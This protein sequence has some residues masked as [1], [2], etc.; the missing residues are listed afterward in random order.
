[1][2][3][4]DLCY[5]LN[6]RTNKFNT[7]VNTTLKMMEPNNGTKHVKFPL[8]HLMVPGNF[9]QPVIR[10]ISQILPPMIVIAKPKMTIH[11]PMVSRFGIITLFYLVYQH[12][13]NGFSSSNR[14]ITGFHSKVNQVYNFWGKDR[15]SLKTCNGKLTLRLN[16]ACLYQQK[17]K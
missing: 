12:H 16:R 7:S 8:C 11:L 6:H 9:S 10:A 15:L 5:R 4:L 13:L 14:F 1:M 2:C 17:R 3:R